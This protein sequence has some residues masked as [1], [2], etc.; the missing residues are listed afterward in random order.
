MRSRTVTMQVV[1]SITMMPAEPMA[2]PAAFSEPPSMLRC[3]HCFKRNAFH[4][5]TTIHGREMTVSLRCIAC[6]RY[7]AEGQFL[8]FAVCY[9]GVLFG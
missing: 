3:P 2:E 5:D 1:S 4:R 8:C 6:Q 9:C 7:G